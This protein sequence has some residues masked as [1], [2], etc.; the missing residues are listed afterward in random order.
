LLVVAA[1]GAGCS[2]RNDAGARSEPVATRAPP[3]A[4]LSRDAAV[5]R[6]DASVAPGTIEVLAL[7]TGTKFRFKGLAIDGQRGRA[8]LG[9]WDRKQLVAVDLR[10]RV[11]RVIPTRYSG[12]LNGMG[13]RLRD[14][15]LYAVMNEVNDAPGARAL[16]VLLVIDAVTLE[17]IR[18]FELRGGRTRHH[19][20][21]VVVDERGIAYVSDTLQA[22]I[23]TVDTTRAD[24]QLRLLLHHPDLTM[25]HGL[26]LPAARATLI[27]TS[28]HSGIL[29]IDL[30]RK[31]LRPSRAPSTAGDDGLAYH[32]GAVYGIGGNA[33]KRYTLNPAEDAVVRT[34]V[35]ILDHPV[36][37]D[38]RCLDISDGWLYGLANIELEPV[39]F[40]G[41]R[42]GA[43]LDDS[44]VVRS[45][46]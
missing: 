4:E 38:P 6:V 30:D 11:H 46:L 40:P 7:G 32:A 41:G 8:F 35:L 17:T 23:Y 15:K 18:S 33:L 25:V 2:G 22:S 31:V 45:R 28:Y 16:S 37:N 5:I 9:S 19:F 42:S 21:H 44:H 36:F 43:A 1:L 34:D 14:D 24:D 27:A 29:F 10:S 39:T 12:K 13:V 3:P 26:T 20:N